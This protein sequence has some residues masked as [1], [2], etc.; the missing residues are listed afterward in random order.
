MRARL[1]IAFLLIATITTTAISQPLIIKDDSPGGEQE[2]EFTP[3]EKQEIR[4]VAEKF[5]KGFK[6]T[7]DIGALIDEIFVSDY[8]ERL[9]LE[10]LRHPFVLVHKDVPL[11]ASPDELKSFLVAL[12]NFWSMMMEL[13]KASECAQESDD[14]QDSGPEKVFPADALKFIKSEPQL[15]HFVSLFIGEEIGAEETIDNQDGSDVDTNEAEDTG[16]FSFRDTQEL[17]ALT[18]AL[19]KAGALMRK[20]L[21]KLPIEKKA[22]E[23]DSESEDDEAIRPSLTILDKDDDFY[24]YPA[25]SQLICVSVIFFHLDLVRIDGR[26]KILAVTPL[27]D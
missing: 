8:A 10:N 12:L 4:E 16:G 1:L 25:G 5:I 9:Q 3:E 17:R 15:A 14:C 27:T 18:G 22:S 26:L 20:H 24:G 6:E 7:R 19:E 13:D 21:S 23:A 2:A 11:I